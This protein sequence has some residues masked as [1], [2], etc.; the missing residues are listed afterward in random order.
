MNKREIDVT[1]NKIAQG[2]NKA[3]ERLYIETRRGIYAFLF[4]YFKNY[5]DCEDALQTTYL[6]IKQNIGQYRESS[7]GLA[8]I[9]QIAKNT[10]LNELKKQKRNESLSVCQS[11]SV[12]EQNNSVIDVMKKV[13][14]EDEYEIVILHVIWGYKH[15]EIAK[16]LNC[17]IGTITSKYNRSVKKIKQALKEVNE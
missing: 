2:D 6:K 4:S 8:W 11:M 3:F 10:A 9:L 14:S 1:L 15:K 5:A 17:P 7:N 13:L 12:D 16:R